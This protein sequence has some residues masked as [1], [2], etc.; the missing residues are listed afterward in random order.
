MT[1][2]P[3]RYRRAVVHHA[4]RA[5]S[6]FG[7]IGSR[8]AVEPVSISLLSRLSRRLKRKDQPVVGEVELSRVAATRFER[9][10]RRGRRR[11]CRASIEISR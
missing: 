11:C 7:F 3:K 2:E 5:I 8:R 6:H 9:T 1:K 10:C 4:I